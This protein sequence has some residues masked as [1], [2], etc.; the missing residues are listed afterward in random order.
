[1][2]LDMFYFQLHMT[3]DVRYNILYSLIIIV[4]LDYSDLFEK[5]QFWS[6]QMLQTHNDQRDLQ[7]MLH[8]VIQ[9]HTGHVLGYF[10]IHFHQI[11]SF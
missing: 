3:S 1:M 8:D 11:R 6:F 4:V 5:Q 9:R 2:L 10:V 7:D